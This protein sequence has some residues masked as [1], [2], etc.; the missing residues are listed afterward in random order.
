M[1]TLGRYEILGELGRGG[2]GVVYR[3]LDP[4]IGRTVAIKTIRAD[5]SGDSLRERFR[6]EARSAGNLSHPNIVT[7][8]EFSDTG[9]IMFIAMEFIDGQTLSQRM[10]GQALA[11]EFVLA[12][13]RA[14]ANALDFAHASNIVHRDVKPANFLITKNGLLKITDFG[15]AK[16]L[17]SD[18]SLT[19]TGMVIGTAQYMSPEQIAAK[20]VTGRS[21][22]FSLG[23][24]AYEMLT[25]QRPFQ[26]N[27]WASM[28]HSIIASEPP[29]LSK[30]RE[31]LGEPVTEVL[32]KALAKEPE[33]RYASC[34]E[35]SDALERSI[36]GTTVE[37]Q[38]FWAET[39]KSPATR[40]LAETLMLTP[41][42]AAWPTAA[43]SPTATVMGTAITP[44]TTTREV[45]PKAAVK[46]PWLVPVVA[47]AVIALGLAAWIGLRSSSPQEQEPTQTAPATAV[48]P[49]PAAPAAAPAE[50]AAP[51]PSKAPEAVESKRPAPAEPRP[52]ADSQ[53]RRTVA[54][55]TPSNP[56]TQVPEPATVPVSAPARTPLQ[57]APVNPPINA[58]PPT[59]AVEAPPAQAAPVARVN[60]PP[61]APPA[62]VAAP[63][64]APAP[65]AAPA[66]V[67]GPD[68]AE[69]AA[70][71]H[72]AELAASRKMVADA[73]GRYRQA[74]ESRDLDALKAAW[75]TLGRNEQNSFQNFFRIARSIKLQLTPVGEPDITPSGATA[76]YRRSMNAS[77]E[78]GTLPAQDQTVKITFRKS[79]DQ[80]SI[81]AIDAVR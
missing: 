56:R 68:P 35:F 54:V 9:E 70:Q 75:P 10:N 17:D 73:V 57:A 29:P 16:M 25:G 2:C 13:V 53:A 31:S 46:R 26:G 24:I 47:G 28:M 23:V 58:P 51:A 20:E 80:M 30:Y 5:G 52:S 72:A 50:A 69:V 65:V 81:D 38:A 71:K 63:A 61:K 32:R 66:P 67:R 64:P 15:I 1:E 48:A 49:E 79:G 21:D 4:G 12:T 60:E 8:H 14:A 36:L 44:P 6:R 33:D 45:P 43:A 7:I 59:A 74:F 42:Q 41:T 27:S 39:A 18:V 19:N 11:L 55:A 40:D 78:R 3:A 34:M 22:Q 76:R 62:P 77:D 37:R